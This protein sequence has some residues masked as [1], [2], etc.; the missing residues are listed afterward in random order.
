MANP[1]SSPAP[2]ENLA[3]IVAR[4]IA[5]STPAVTA[6]R[7]GPPNIRPPSSVRRN[8]GRTSPYSGRGASSI[9]ISTLPSTPS[10]SRSSSCGAPIPR[11]CARWPSTKAIASSSRT[12]PARS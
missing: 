10:T 2:I 12:A 8:S 5:A 1:A 3:S 11:S 7:S 6:I 4:S 9:A